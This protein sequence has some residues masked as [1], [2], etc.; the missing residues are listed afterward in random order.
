[1]QVLLLILGGVLA[2]GL[3]TMN[4]RGRRRFWHSWIDIGLLPLL[5]GLAC[6]ALAWQLLPSGSEQRLNDHLH[7]LL[8]LAQATAGVLLG[9]QLRMAYLVRAGWG[10]MRHQNGQIAMVA[11][12]S[13]AVVVGVLGLDG[14]SLGT[15]LAAAALLV[16]LLISSSQRPPPSS[17]AHEHRHKDVISRHVAGAGWWNL[18]AVLLAGIGLQAGLSPDRPVALA[19]LPD[20]VLAVV[21]TWVFTLAAAC[22]AGLGLGLLSKGARNRAEASLFL[23]AVLGITGGGALLLGGAPLLTGVVVGAWFSNIALGRLALIER[24]LI[25]LEQPVVIAVAYL[26][27]VAVVLITTMN[28]AA[29]ASTWNLEPMTLAVLAAMLMRW[30]LRWRWSPTDPRLAGAGERALASPGATGLLL[31]TSCILAPAELEPLIIPMLIGLVL[32][33][34]VA[35]LVEW[36]VLRLAGDDEG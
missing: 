21:P 27:G 11:V 15:L 2:L 35:E 16:G 4:K 26:A 34:L 14:L 30:L 19:L 31:L 10:F 17:Y 23:L 9:T 1:V 36:R 33:H 18:M 5:V 24:Q 12:L 13:A 20:A 25:D 7:A 6:G 28:P 32:L 29:W 3:P 8:A 22:L